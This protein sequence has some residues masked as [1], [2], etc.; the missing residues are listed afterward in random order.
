MP[1]PP[2]DC[3]AIA[4]SERRR[5]GTCKRERGRGREKREGK[6]EGKRERGQREGEGRKKGLNHV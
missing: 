5:E 2:G 6:S 4:R 3:L 1:P